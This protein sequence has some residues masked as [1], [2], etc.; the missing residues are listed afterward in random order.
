MGVALVGAA[1]AVAPAGAHEVPTEQVVQMFVLPEDAELVV[2]LRIPTAILAD[3]NLPKTVDGRL[4]LRDLDPALRLVARDAADQLEFEQDGVPLAARRTRAIVSAWPDASFTTA[5]T[6][7]DHLRRDS[8]SSDR[9]LL[10]NQ[11]YVDVELGYARARSGHGPSARLNP[12]RSPGQNVRTVVVYV[13]P[14]GA[15]RTFSLVGTPE[16]LE[17]DPDRSDTVRDFASRALRALAERGHWLLFLV[18]LACCPR[19]DNQQAVM[20][21]GL[22]QAIAFPAGAVWGLTPDARVALELAAASCLVMAGLDT[23][24]GASTCRSAPPGKRHHR[25]LW[26]IAL[27]FGL[28][29]GL[30]FGQGFHGAAV[31]AG[32]HAGAA[33]LAFGTVVAAAQLWAVAMLSAL[34]SLA[35]RGGLPNPIVTVVVSIVVSHTGV[36]WM[37]ERAEQLAG[38]GAVTVEHAIGILALGWASLVLGAALLDGFLAGRRH[39]AAHGTLAGAGGQPIP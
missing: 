39:G 20:A 30:S 2:L 29:I 35:C 31:F 27:L 4:R 6:A 18:C 37:V 11:A 14:S 9:D 7:R 8:P 19:S 23:L 10:W 5:K 3:A 28:F 24:T 13:A 21:L 25:L 33:L 17:L 1:V 36:H 34:I 32:S 22:G 38:F 15:T 16:R 26:P 12:F